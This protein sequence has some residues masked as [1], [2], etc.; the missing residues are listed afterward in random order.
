M[1]HISLTNV[2]NVAFTVYHNVS[3]V[4]IL[5][6]QDITGNRVGSHGLDEVQTCLLE[7]YGVWTTVLG[8]EE[9]KQIINLGTTHFIT[10]RGIRNNI[11]NTALE[12]QSAPED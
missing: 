10:G 12:C 4:P 7:G 8:N 6:L 1:H 2:D 3:I 11:N 5:D 9:I